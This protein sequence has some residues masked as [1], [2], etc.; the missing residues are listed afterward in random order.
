MSKRDISFDEYYITNLVNSEIKNLENNEET[1]IYVENIPL[2]YSCL[3]EIKQGNYICEICK[4]NLCEIH[5]T[6]HLKIN[7]EHKIITL[8]HK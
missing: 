5:K 2:C 8:I 7:P 3:F 6:N 1:I 4:I